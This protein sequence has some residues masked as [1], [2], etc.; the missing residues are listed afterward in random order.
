MESRLALRSLSVGK[1]LKKRAPKTLAHQ[2]AL[3][4]MATLPSALIRPSTAA[5]GRSK[6]GSAHYRRGG[7]SV[8]ALVEPVTIGD[9]T[10]ASS[11]LRNESGFGAGANMADVAGARL[12]KRVMVL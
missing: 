7:V 3:Q 10:A 5:P 4:P 12:K 8:R 6:I 2:Q 11:D 1:Q 9:G